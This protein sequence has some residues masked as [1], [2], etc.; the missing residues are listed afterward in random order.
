MRSIIY[1]IPIALIFSAT[2][3]GQGFIVDYQDA[4]V[5]K[6]N[7]D[8][9]F[10]KVQ[11]HQVNESELAPSGEGLV[12]YKLGNNTKELSIKMSE[13]QS[14]KTDHG[15]Y[16]NVH[17]DRRELLFKVAVE[18]NVSLLEYP[19]ISI[20]L[21]RGI[22]KFGPKEITYYAIKTNNQTVVIKQRKD[23]NAFM[24]IIDKC[25]GAKAFVNSKTF[26]IDN[27]KPLV[28]SLNRCK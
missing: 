13:I 19:R 16:L 15:V 8:S 28:D 6:K 10:C 1:I 2:L 25:P 20:I 17:V 22:E 3:S 18:G 11:L 21:D 12:I 9:L 5:F 24:D 7:K 14:I 26:K 4:I 27:L 23:I